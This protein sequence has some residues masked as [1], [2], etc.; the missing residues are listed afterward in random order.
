L[1]IVDEKTYKNF[2]KVQAETYTQYSQEQILNELISGLRFRANK[3]LELTNTLELLRPK[4]TLE[5]NTDEK[6]MTDVIEEF[7]T[8]F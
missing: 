7:L 2:S 1:I 3:I 5:Q 6:I 4:I 8:L